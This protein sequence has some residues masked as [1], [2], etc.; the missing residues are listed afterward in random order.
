MVST[1]D[2]SQGCDA[3]MVIISFLRGTSGHMGFIKDIQR[4]NVAMTR[5]KFQLVSV[6]NVDAI[7]GLTETGGNLVLRAMAQGAL[8][9]SKI[10]PSPDPLPPSPK[11]VSE[12]NDDYPIP[13]IVSIPSLP[14]HSIE[15]EGSSE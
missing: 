11:R 4:L 1:V 2:A 8:L 14:T 5:A 3:D 15:T 6:G 10:V 13:A 7:A 9:R 12:D